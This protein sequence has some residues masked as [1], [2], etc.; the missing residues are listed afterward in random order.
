MSY[1]R[2]LERALKSALDEIERLR[3]TVSWYNQKN[4]EWQEK[5]DTETNTLKARV[6]ELEVEEKQVCEWAKT[7]T[8]SRLGLRHHYHI[9]CLE[10][11][12][13]LN[14][15]DGNYCKFCGKRIKYV[16]SVSS[17]EVE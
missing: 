17:V 10:Q 15:S 13:L 1:T 8:G 6:A 5:Y 11:Y 16:E 7:K 2:D 12:R 3:K 14:D 9:S 4:I